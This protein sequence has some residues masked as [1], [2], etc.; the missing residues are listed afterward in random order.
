MDTPN[1]ASKGSGGGSGRTAKGR[2]WQRRPLA[3]RLDLTPEQI[4]SREAERQRR[5]R[6]AHIGIQ[7]TPDERAEIE[8]RAKASG[9]RLSD[10]VRIVL[11]SELKAP[12]PSKTDP[13]AV[14]ALAF[15]LSKIGT[16]LNQLAKVANETHR[17]NFAARLK[18]IAAQIEG[19][20]AHVIEL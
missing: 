9:N 1:A 17:L 5:K 8:R 3:R 19:S 7:V 12:L 2:R 20:L 18:A 16:N 15:Q 10:Y 11:L 14:M 4:A 13:Q 6:T